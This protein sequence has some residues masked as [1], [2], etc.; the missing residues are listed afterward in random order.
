[1]TVV[2]GYRADTLRSWVRLGRIDTLLVNDEWESSNMVT[3]LLLAL[4]QESVA[5]HSRTIVSYSDIFYEPA[6]VEALARSDASFAVAYDPDGVD[7]W[8]CRFADPLGDLE[9]FQIGGD[10]IITRIG[11]PV[12]ATSGVQGQYMGLL[13]LSPDACRSIQAAVDPLVDTQLDMTSLLQ[14]LVASGICL[15]GVP[16]GDRWGEIDSPEDLEFFRDAG[17]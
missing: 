5:R 2:A 17:A 4:Q 9:D 14:R 1:M 8:T 16:N 15:K 7:L 10:G 11:S 3:S 13:A 6:I 12:L